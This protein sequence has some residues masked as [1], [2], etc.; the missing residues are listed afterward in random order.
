MLSRSA[1][2]P[3][4]QNAP[5]PA[6]KVAEA[7]KQWLRG[8]RCA[9]DGADCRGKIEAAHMPDPG[10]KGLGTKAA[11]CNCIPAC[12][13]HHQLHTNKG[14]SALGLTREQASKLAEDYWQAWPGRKAWEAKNA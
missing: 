12:Q 11:D 4:R 2:K 13:H 5:R 14:W 6:W 3:R 7:F 9:F 8:R 1:L 10:S